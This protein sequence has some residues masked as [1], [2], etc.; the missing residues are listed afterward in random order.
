MRW[1]A[2]QPADMSFFESAPIVYRF[3]VELPVPP[4]RVWE[5]LQSDE[6]LAAWGLGVKL[7]WTSPRPFGV[8]TTREVVLPGRSMTLREHFFRW[9]EGSGYSF[10]VEQANRGMFTRF[11][12]DYVVEATP[13]GSRFTWTVALEPKPKVLPWLKRT[14]AA[15]R[16]A[17]GR[18]AA[19]AKRYV[20]KHPVSA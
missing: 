19:A 4:E 9:D 18:T 17:F 2:L 5:S 1:H 10:Y 13:T 14:D 12:E 3:P 11:A 16:F 7:R 15:G 8:R 6:S 20:A